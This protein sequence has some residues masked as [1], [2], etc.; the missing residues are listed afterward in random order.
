M[1]DVFFLL[2]QEPL[3]LQCVLSKDYMMRKLTAS[4]PE[5]A[6]IGFLQP[7]TAEQAL[8]LARALV[9]HPDV[10]K[11]LIEQQRAVIAQQEALRAAVEN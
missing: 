7:M 3:G 2:N 5:T 10:Q 1:I 11:L 4:D 8:G 9:Q 6:G